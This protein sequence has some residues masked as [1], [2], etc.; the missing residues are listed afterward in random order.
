MLVQ[1]T[2]PTALRRAE[3]SIKTTSIAGTASRL[4]G[5]DAGDWSILVIGL[6]LAILLASMV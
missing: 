5:L 6:A 3:L 2:V 4:F 1:K